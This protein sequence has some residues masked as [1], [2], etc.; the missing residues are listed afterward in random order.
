MGLPKIIDNNRKQLGAVLQRLSRDHD[1]LSIATGYWDLPGTQ[2]L[3][4]EIKNYK[5]IRLLIGQEP[6][7]PRHKKKLG[8]DSPHPDFPDQDINFDL[9]E[10]PQEDS[11][12]Q[13]ISYLKQLI[14]EGRLEVRIYR[15]D[16]LH[17]KCY[18]F[19]N[20]ESEEAVGIIGSSNFTG[21]GLTANAELNA[22]E[23]DYRIVKY[24]PQNDTDDQGHLS[25][26]DKVWNDE[27]TEIWDGKFKQILGD[28]PVGDMTYSPYEMYI[29][30]LWEIYEDEV[31]EGKHLGEEITDPLYGFQKRNAELL[32][33]KL[34]KHG[35]AML[36]DSVGLGKTITAGAVLKHYK[37]VEKAK[38]IYVIAPAGLREQWKKDL[39]EKLSLFGVETLSMQNLREVREARKIDKYAEVD[40]FI[41]DE[42]HNLRSDIGSRHNEFLDWFGENPNSKVLLLTA[43]PINNRLTDINHQIQ[44]AAKG[45]LR[46][47]KVTYPGESKIEYLDFFEATRRLQSDISRA[48]KKGQKPDFKKISDVMRQGLPHFLVRTTRKG[49]EKYGGSLTKGRKQKSFPEGRV[50]GGPY[51]FNPELSER[52]KQLLGDNSSKFSDRDPTKLPLDFLL[53]QTQYTKHPLDSLDGVQDENVQTNVFINIYQAIQLLGFTSYRPMTYRRR[54]YGKSTEEIASMGLPPSISFPLRSQ[55]SIHNMLMQIFLKRLE[56]SA[57][58]LRTSLERYGDR[59][60]NFSRDLDEGFVVSVEDHQIIA[61]EFGDDLE[62]IID[63]ESQSAVDQE[64]KKEALSEGLYDI[65]ALR[66]D[67]A[68]D[69]AVLDVLLEACRLIEEKDD[70]L[71]AFAKLLRQLIDNPLAGRKIL[72]YSYYADTIAYLENKLPAIIGTDNFRKK[73]AFVSGKSKSKVESIAERF[74]PKSKGAQGNIQPDDEIDYLFSTDVLSE[75]QNLQDCGVLINFD[76]HWN[77]VRMIQRNGRINRLGSDHEEVFIYNMHPEINLEDYLRLVQRLERKIDYIKHSIGTDQSVL[78]E[79]AR[80]IEYID[81]VEAQSQSPLSNVYNPDKAGEAYQSII[82][83]NEQLIAENEYIDDLR[84]FM[85]GADENS[86]DRIK[87]IPP[88]K[89]GYMSAQTISPRRPAVMGLT[90][91]QGKILEAQHSFKNHVFVEAIPPWDNPSITVMETIEALRCLRTNADDNNPRPDKIVCDRNLIKRR[92]LLQAERRADQAEA[93]GSN[94]EKPSH[95]KILNWLSAEVPHLRIGDRLGLIA[96]KQDEKAT[97][98][99]FRRANKE[100]KERGSL[101]QDIVE[102]FEAL[103]VK[104]EEHGSKQSR[105]VT[106]VEG[107]LFYARD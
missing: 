11:Y 32:I 60:K 77:P 107:V 37:E 69:R 90:C 85:E 105:Q 31:L 92:S 25:W 17:A 51:N 57:Y 34:D 75:G 70:K 106:K 94:F 76:L 52:I 47:L 91:A 1:H 27:T 54:F 71:M 84:H 40:L 28:S 3:F 64:T 33:K 41:I 83:D 80:P 103:A 29:K 50:K 22:L 18:I 79:E 73:A 66:S 81:R 46:F 38:R 5:S 74:S 9:T 86:K 26:F 36:A 13:L 12:R 101:S 87:N 21:A 30:T 16:F 63:E 88:N 61:N 100:L 42:A 104:L 10:L 99:L 98:S 96:N 49:V 68:K 53:K 102:A 78:G 39:A 4:E 55:M 62:L 24:R 48:E 82:D 15:R 19:G 72:V 14:D 89:W 65:E 59:L 8:I 44:L 23:D 43:T 2:L 45:S 7:I 97:R 6:L 67:I 20:Y 56:S 93:G 35:L 58:S 95:R